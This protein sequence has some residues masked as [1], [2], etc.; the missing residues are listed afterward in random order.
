MDGAELPGSS[1]H[2]GSSPSG[3]VEH[4]ER[5][6]VPP[7]TLVGGQLTP[8]SPDTEQGPQVAKSLSMPRSQK[9]MPES[10]EY[11][12]SRLPRVGS[13]RAPPIHRDFFVGRR[14]WGGEGTER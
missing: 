12:L 8:H 10:H 6:D 13:R 11:M 4:R 1:G 9:P 2:I 5:P 14:G 7:V 3:L